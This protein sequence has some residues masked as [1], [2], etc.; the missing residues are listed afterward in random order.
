MSARD[1][2]HQ[3]VKNALQKE[4]WTITHDP[5]EISSGGV[6]MKIDLGA[7]K[8]IGAERNGKRIAVEIKSF[9][10]QSTVNQFHTALGQFINYQYALEVEEPNRT[11]Y[12]A[13]PITIYQDFFTLEFTRAIVRRNQLK[14]IVY[15]V[16]QEV[17]VQWLN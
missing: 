12:L 3:V 11:L 14:L 10:G 17:I 16:E 1:R 15:D 5:L 2:F 9:V 13:V 7:E 6:D 4:A 8:V